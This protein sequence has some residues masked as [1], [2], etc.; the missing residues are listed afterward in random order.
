[1]PLSEAWLCHVRG[2][3]G[4]LEEQSLLRETTRSDN[5]IVTHFGTNDYLGIAQRR[6]PDRA[7]AN[8]EGGREYRGSVLVSGYSKAHENLEDKILELKGLSRRR[9]SRALLFPSGYAANLSVGMALCTVHE[10]QD[11]SQT[12]HVYSDSLNHASIIDGIRYARATTRRGTGRSVL[13]IYKHNDARDLRAKL[14]EENESG[15]KIVFTESV[16]SMDGD[17]CDLRG[18]VRL[19]R[20]HKF[21]LV[22]DEAHATLVLGDKG[23]GLAQALGLSSEVDLSVGTLSKAVGSLGGFVVA[24]TPLLRSIVLNKGRPV[25]YSTSLPVALVEQACDNICFGMSKEGRKLRQRLRKNV[26]LLVRALAKRGFL[27]GSGAMDGELVSPIVPVDMPSER[28][29][30]EA[31]LYLRKNHKIFVPAIR[32]PTVPTSRLRIAVCAMHS[33]QELLSLADAVAEF[34]RHH[35]L[36]SKL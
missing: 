35:R 3:L 1:M 17:V 24:H 29:A 21:L 16:F 36:R 22:L 6:L 27:C 28:Y 5:G 33:E 12:I 14:E 34:E 26:T 11:P 4:R 7:A 9:G 30:M 23:G 31:S 2:A 25:I 20:E 19:K 8:G 32:P 10:G 13:H 18:I 15:L